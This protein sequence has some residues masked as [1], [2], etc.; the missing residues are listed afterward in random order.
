LNQGWTRS[1]VAI[2]L[3]RIEV[4]DTYR[5]RLQGVFRFSNIAVDLVEPRRL[6]TRKVEWS[7]FGEEE[8]YQHD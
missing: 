3:D 2:V 5:L 1:A 7:Y 8:L 6:A 4:N